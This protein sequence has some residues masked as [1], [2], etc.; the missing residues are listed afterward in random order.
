[1]HGAAGVRLQV[2]PAVGVWREVVGL[3]AAWVRLEVRRAA[4]IWGQVVPGLCAAGVRREVR[5][6]AREGGLVGGV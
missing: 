4:G 2:P 5:L 3:Q 1:V 6:D